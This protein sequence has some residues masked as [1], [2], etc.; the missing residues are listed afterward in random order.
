MA[1]KNRNYLLPCFLS[2]ASFKFYFNKFFLRRNIKNETNFAALLKQKKTV[3]T[4]LTHPDF[5]K[6][7]RTQ[8]VC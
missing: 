7:K 1:A 2:I 6:N 4:K 3:E 8:S 5:L